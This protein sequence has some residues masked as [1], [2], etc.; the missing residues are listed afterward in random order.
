MTEI[1]HF[2]VPFQFAN[3]VAAVNEQ[4]SADDI[5]ACVLAI[6]S[7]TLGSRIEKPDF[8]VPD[9]TFRQGGV[10]GATLAAAITRWEPRAD[11]TVDVDNSYLA[12]RISSATVA[13]KETI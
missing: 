3:G 9:Q 6:A 13:T 8:G 5:E 4:D 12:N 2:A 1:P 11:A 10:D 7:Y